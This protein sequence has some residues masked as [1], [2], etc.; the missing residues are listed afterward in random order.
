MDPFDDF[1]SEVKSF[2]KYQLKIYKIKDSVWTVVTPYPLLLY[3]YML[4]S[5]KKLKIQEITFHKFKPRQALHAH[6]SLS[7]FLGITTRNEWWT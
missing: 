2:L 7:N 3:S 6:A 5:P 1:F 4:Q